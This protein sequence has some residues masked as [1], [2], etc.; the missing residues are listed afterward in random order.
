MAYNNENIFSYPPKTNL[1]NIDTK[2][3]CPV[4]KDLMKNVHQA[5]DCG[6][7]YC[8]E[9]LDTFLKDNKVCI[10]CNFLFASNSKIPDKYFQNKINLQQVKCDIKECVWIGTIIDYRVHYNSHFKISKV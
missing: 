9:C 6:C 1:I 4:C 2:F 8:Y 7:K 10:K 3:F 5:D